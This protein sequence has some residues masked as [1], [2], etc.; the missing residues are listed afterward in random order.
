MAVRIL[1][2]LMFSAALLAGLAGC[3]SPASSPHSGQPT[4]QGQSM[5]LM[6]ADIERIRAFVYG[7]SAS[8]S[9]AEKA[10]V[11]LVSWSRRMGELFPPGQASTEYVDMDPGRVGRAPEEMTRSAERLLATV[12]TGKRP[13]IGDQ[14]TR[15]ETD[16]CGVCHLSTVR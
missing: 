6:L 12:R 1:T 4:V 9:D 13:A 16:G 10:A 7:G 8:K 5:Q 11:D 2:H 15:T 14:L 3:T